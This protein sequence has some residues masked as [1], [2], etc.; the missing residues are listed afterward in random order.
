M[1]SLPLI[2][3]D[4]R[5]TVFVHVAA[6]VTACYV[7]PSN[8]WLSV[9]P[10]DASHGVGA[11]RVWVPRVV[12]RRPTQ[13]LRKAMRCRHRAVVPGSP[14]VRLR[15]DGAHEAVGAVRV[16]RAAGMRIWLPKIEASLA[17]LAVASCD[18]LECGFLC[19]CGVVSCS[20]VELHLHPPRFSDA[21][22]ILYW[23]L[24]SQRGIAARGAFADAVLP[25][26]AF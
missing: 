9:R 16:R 6:D 8:P 18:C 1:F 11:R 3:R 17:S 23:K 21:F 2:R 24:A 25:V 7:L 26:Q 13:G 12:S 15:R 22:R 20:L 10:V 14:H 4:V 19:T 5:I